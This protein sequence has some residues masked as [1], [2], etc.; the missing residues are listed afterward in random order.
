[1]PEAV[2]HFAAFAYVGESVEM[3]DKY[4]R[5]NVVGSLTLLETMKN[6]EINKIVFS[7]SCATY[8]KPLFPTISEDH[9]Q[10]PMNPYG[11]SKLIVEQ[12]LKDFD[13]AYGI[14]SI[15]LRY[16]NAAGADPDCEIGE[17]HSPETH[18]IPLLIDVALGICSHITINGDD[19]STPDGTCIRDYVHVAD[20]AEAHVL[21]LKK[22]EV[23]HESRTFNIGNGL[24]YSV[25]EIIAATED[26]IGKKIS[27]KIG[28]RR[29]G[30]PDCLVS[31]PRNAMIELGWK[32]QY[33]DITMILHHAYKWHNRRINKG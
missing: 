25:K 9:I 7:S 10:K 23:T 15:A 32:P 11:W 19:Y 14:K 17:D 18:L 24:G 8:G 16:F 27:V 3:P 33:G 29:S 26:V 1:M 2:I 28:Q 5:N 12:M 4:Y 6:H 30:D 20:L 22:L 13:R 21:A 31:E